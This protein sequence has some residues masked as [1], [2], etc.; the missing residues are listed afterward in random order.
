[1]ERLVTGECLP[2]GP[3]LLY[4]LIWSRRTS[5]TNFTRWLKDCLVKQGMYTQH[6]EK[7]LKTV[8][9]AVNNLKYDITTAKNCIMALT[10]DVKKGMFLVT[11]HSSTLEW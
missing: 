2:S 5:H 10:P 7:L 1:M 11:Y 9:D 8:S 4:S 3:L 6:S